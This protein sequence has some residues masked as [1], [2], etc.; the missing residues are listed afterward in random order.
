MVVML[1]LQFLL[2]VSVRNRSLQRNVFLQRPGRCLKNLK[3]T[4]AFETRELRRSHL[5]HV[6]GWTRITA[7]RH[8]LHVAV[9]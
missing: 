7:S 5:W 8:R 3:V 2:V 1:T 9:L 6:S 4:T